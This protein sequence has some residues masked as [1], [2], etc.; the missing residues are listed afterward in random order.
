MKEQVAALEYSL[1]HEYNTPEQE[2]SKNRVIEYLTKR[3]NGTI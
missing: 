2:E 1:I 3:I